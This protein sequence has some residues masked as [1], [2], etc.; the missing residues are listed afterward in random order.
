MVTIGFPRSSYLTGVSFP[1][2]KS[3]RVPN[4]WTFGLFVIFLLGFF[5]HSSLIVFAYLDIS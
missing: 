2:N 5:I 1:D 4:T 3:D